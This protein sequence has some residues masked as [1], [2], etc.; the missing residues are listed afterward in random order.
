MWICCREKDGD[1][2][3]GSSAGKGEVTTCLLKLLRQR[4]ED[5]LTRRRMAKEKRNKTGK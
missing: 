2:L 3:G 1:Q 5:K 4:H